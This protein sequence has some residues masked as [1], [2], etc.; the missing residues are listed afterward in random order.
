MAVL[1]CEDT[2]SIII[3]SKVSGIALHGVEELLIES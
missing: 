1:I 2:I 3:W